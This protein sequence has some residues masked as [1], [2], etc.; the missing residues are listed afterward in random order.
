MQNKIQQLIEESERSLAPQFHRLEQ[1]AYHNQKKVLQAFQNNR[2]ALR[3]FAP[4]SG[5]GY[6]DEGRDTLGA[7][8]ADIFGAEAGIV[9]PNILSGTHALTVGLFGLLCTGDTLFSI[10]GDPYDA[11]HEVIAGKGIG[12]LADYGIS[13]KKC[14]LSEGEFD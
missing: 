5:Y 4:T 12:S 6:G 1:I 13:F 8:F 9:S 14:D 7:L 2:I 11:L 3:H 10:A